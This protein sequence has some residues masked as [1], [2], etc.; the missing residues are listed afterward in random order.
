MSM[1]QA[2]VL[3]SIITPEGARPSRQHVSPGP[4]G[5][6]PVTVTLPAFAFERLCTLG[7]VIDMDGYKALQHADEEAARVLE[8]AQALAKET[9][10]RALE[11]ARTGTLEDE[12]VRLDDMKKPQLVELAKR[13]DLGVNI[14]RAEHNLRDDIRVELTERMAKLEGRDEPE[15]AD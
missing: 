11:K 15:P 3:K 12:L 5:G 6:A 10:R 14:R 7:C 2:V 9:R 8:D 13:M 4:E 1:I